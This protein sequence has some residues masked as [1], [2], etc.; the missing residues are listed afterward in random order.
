M[1]TEIVKKLLKTMHNKKK[2]YNKI[3]K[4]ARIKLNSSESKISEV[5]INNET[6]HEDF[7]A[8]IN[9]E[10]NCREFKKSIR[11]MKSQISD[12]EKIN[13]IEEGKKI[14]SD[15]VIKHNEFINNTLKS[16]I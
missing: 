16:Q 7:M 6:S 9:K 3:V 10:R 5:L 14:G 4:L 1:S 11:M 12:T 15:E 2:K 13:L 8:I